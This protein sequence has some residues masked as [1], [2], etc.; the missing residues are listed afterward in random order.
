[1]RAAR[2]PRTIIATAA[3]VVGLACLTPFVYLFIAGVSADSL[4]QIFTYPNTLSDI[5]RTLALALVIAAACIVIGVGA[6]LVVVR[7]DVPLRRLLTVA[8]TLPL[9]VPGFVSAYAFYSANLV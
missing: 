5:F 2:L 4:R 8:L 3:I 9:A 7:T 6:A 1:M